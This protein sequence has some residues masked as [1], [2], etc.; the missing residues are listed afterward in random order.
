MTKNRTVTYTPFVHRCLPL[1]PTPFTY[2]LILPL[3]YFHPFDM[4]A[5]SISAHVCLPLKSSPHNLAFCMTDHP[6]ERLVFYS[7]T[8]FK[9]FPRD[10]CS[11]L[12]ISTPIPLLL[13][14]LCRLFL[15]SLFPF[16]TSPF[17]HLFLAYLSYSSGFLTFTFIVS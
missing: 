13:Y 12:I 10:L 2:R 5:S 6:L 14:L 9:L 15:F 11:L 16:I 17:F 7:S 4:S 8:C 1:P 3:L